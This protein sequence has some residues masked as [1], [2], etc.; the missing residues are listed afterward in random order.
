MFTVPMSSL[1][2]SL[3]DMLVKDIDERFLQQIR[4][5][6]QQDLMTLV[7]GITNDI[8]AVSACECKTMHGIK[9]E[10]MNLVQLAITCKH[11]SPSDPPLPS[12]ENQPKNF[13]VKSVTKRG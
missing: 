1:R 10:T 13:V 6:L 11:K 7:R 8:A 5:T 9:E 2:I 3:S 4:S 12:T